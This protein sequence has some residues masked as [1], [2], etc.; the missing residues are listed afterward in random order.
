MCVCV[1]VCVCVCACVCVCTCVHN[2]GWD[3]VEDE[4]ADDNN[5]NVYFNTAYLDVGSFN[6]IIIM[7]VLFLMFHLKK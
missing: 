7:R 3:R 4:G 6:Y 1:C 2:G 5:K